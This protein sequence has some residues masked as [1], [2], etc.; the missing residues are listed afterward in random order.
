V[1]YIAILAGSGGGGW[2]VWMPGNVAS[3]RGNDNR[4]L[5]FRL[6]GGSTPLPPMLEAVTP[7]PEPA[8]QPGTS[9][10]IAAGSALF[11]RNCAGCHSN[12]DRAAVP[13]LRRSAF[14]RDA[15]AF[16]SVVRGGVL[17]KRGMPSWDD[18]LS[19]VEVEQ[20]R[21]HL[22]SIARDAYAKQQTGASSVPVSVLR[23]GHP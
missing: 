1:Q 2:N 11:S 5:A 6:D 15:A 16:Q 19:A 18:L 10:D 17:E 9:A 7:I 12:A 3:E 20:I 13:D 22:V 21:A 14:L 4:I 8:A 23:E